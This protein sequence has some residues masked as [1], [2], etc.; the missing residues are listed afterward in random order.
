MNIYIVYKI[1]LWSFTWTTDF[2]LANSLFE[3]V[4]VTKNPILD[5]YKYSTYGIGFDSSRSFAFGSGFGKN[6]IIFGADMCSSIIL[7]IKKD[8]GKDKGPTQGLGDTTL[9]AE[10]EYSIHF[11]E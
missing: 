9:T 1:N 7:I 3:A 2:M 10:K 5:E 11:S 6:I 8:K 4:K